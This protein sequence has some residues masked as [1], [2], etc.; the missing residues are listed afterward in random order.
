M[1]GPLAQVCRADM[2]RKRFPA[3]AAGA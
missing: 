3:R 1:N 2:S